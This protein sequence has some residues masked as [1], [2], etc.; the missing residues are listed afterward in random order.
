M[1]HLETVLLALV[2]NETWA[3]EVNEAPSALGTSNC[4]YG[5]VWENGCVPGGL[6]RLLD[7]PVCADESA[8]TNHQ[9]ATEQVEV[10]PRSLAEGEEA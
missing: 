5:G 7:H 1:A 8:Q 3:G 4:A 9:V 6:Q 2:L 10:V